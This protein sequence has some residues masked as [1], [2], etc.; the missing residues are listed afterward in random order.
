[1]GG[2][3]PKAKNG[4]FISRRLIFRVGGR[5]KEKQIVLEL[6]DKAITMRFLTFLMLLSCYSASKEAYTLYNKEGN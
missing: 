5:N 2:E 1:M 6:L 3:A 4:V